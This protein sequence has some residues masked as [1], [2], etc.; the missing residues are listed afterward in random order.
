MRS[1]T[2]Q[3]FEKCRTCG[4]PCK[5]IRPPK[6]LRLGELHVFRFLQQSPSEIVR[7]P[8]LGGS[9][10]SG[11]EISGE[12]PAVATRHAEIV[13]TLRGHLNRAGYAPGTVE[14][15]C[16]RLL[17]LPVSP[18]RA[19]QADVVASLGVNTSPQS[20][21]VYLSALHAAYRDLIMLGVV[22]HDP[23]I[24][25]RLPTRGRTTPRPLTDEQL[26]RLLDGRGPER[27][28]TVLGAYAG[29]RAAEVVNLY[30]EDLTMTAYGYAIQVVGK[31]D[32][33]SLIPAHPL[34]VDLFAPGQRGPLWR[35]RPD[36]M[37]Q[38]W[39]VWAENLGEPGLRF[40]QLRH[41]YGTRLYRSTQ[42]LLATSKLMRHA[43]INT[44]TVYAGLAD[45]TGFKAVA[46]L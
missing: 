45:D 26:L 35:M 20:K 25:V 32:V 13:E 16:N 39:G 38:R 4:V 18:E 30:A 6:R 15:R 33:K 46:N 14:Q 40:H 12:E 22:H 43:N 21:R 11:V 41:T 34:V 17:A 8:R 42:D 28:W 24:G 36:T 1:L 10:Q 7:T 19:N 37:S 9:L 5:R 29:L 2:V 44:T 23:T 31:N 27:A 3:G